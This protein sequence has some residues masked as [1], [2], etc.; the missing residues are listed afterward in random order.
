MTLGGRVG[1]ELGLGRF[2]CRSVLVSPAADVLQWRR[3]TDN[4]HRDKNI[5][6]YI[7]IYIFIEIQSDAR[8]QH[9]DEADKESCSDI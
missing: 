5:Y 3:G 2:T 8:Q 7:Y 6:I 4:Q 1:A 9:K